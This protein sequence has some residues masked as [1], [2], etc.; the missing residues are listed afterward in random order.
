M[1]PRMIKRIFAHGGRWTR[2]L[3]FFLEPLNTSD[4]FF[5][6]Y[7]MYLPILNLATVKVRYSIISVGDVTGVEV[8]NQ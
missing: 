2:G 4:R 7:T 8:Y 3:G 6:T 5:F 1:R